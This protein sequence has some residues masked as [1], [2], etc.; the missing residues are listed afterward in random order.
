MQGQVMHRKLIDYL[1]AK[2]VGR[3]VEL[4]QIAVMGD[5]SSGKSSLLTA[6]SNIQFPSNDQITTRCPVR[7]RME[8]SSDNTRIRVGVKWHASSAY[9]N[10]DSWPVQEFDQFEPITE[11]WILAIVE[12]IFQSI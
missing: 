1:H 8:K 6:I 9:K 5:T 12:S 7:L 2:D 4:P 11:V 10:D 3:Y